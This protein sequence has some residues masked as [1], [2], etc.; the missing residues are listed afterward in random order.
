MSCVRQWAPHESGCL[1]TPVWPPGDLMPD[2]IIITCSSHGCSAQ[3]CLG[4]LTI[5]SSWDDC[6]DAAL[7]RGWAIGPKVC[8]CPTCHNAMTDAVVDDL[9]AEEPP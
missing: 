4:D 9:F 6:I 8:Y 1:W 7:I 3:V 2:A 5:E